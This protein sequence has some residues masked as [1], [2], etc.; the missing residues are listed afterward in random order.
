[1]T[2]WTLGSS[3]PIALTISLVPA[4]SPLTVQAAPL[5]APPATGILN[6]LC[7]DYVPKIEKLAP[8]KDALEPALAHLGTLYPKPLAPFAA[9]PS[10]IAAAMWPLARAPAMALPCRRL[11]VLNR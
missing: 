10:S 6:S 9:E 8:G 1:M 5:N 7:Y 4:L 2:K 3:Y 11:T